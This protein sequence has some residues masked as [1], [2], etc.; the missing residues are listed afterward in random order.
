MT[1]AQ[2]KRIAEKMFRRVDVKRDSIDLVL[3]SE[4]LIRFFKKG[5]INE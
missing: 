5:K 3:R 4:G 2:R 1:D